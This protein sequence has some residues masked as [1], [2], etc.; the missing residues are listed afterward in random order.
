MI[1]IFS[2]YGD[3]TTTQVCEWLSFYEVDFIRVNGDKEV[4]FDSYDNV[5]NEIVFKINNRKVNLNQAAIVWYRKAGLGL[6]HFKSNYQ[7]KDA[8][9]FLEGGN[10]LKHVVKNENKTLAKYFHWEIEKKQTL[11]KEYNA[12]LNKLKTL[13]IAKECGLNVPKSYVLTSKK[14]LIKLLDCEEA[15]ISK[16]IKDGI[17]EFRENHAYYTYSEK[18]VKEN[19]KDYPDIFSP[20][21][22]QGLIDKKYELRVFFFDNRFYSMAIFSQEYETTSIDYRRSSD[23][24][25]RKIPFELPREQKSKLKDLMNKLDLNTGS[26]DIIVDKENNYVFL[27]VNPVGQFSMVSNPCNYYLEQ[28]V[29]N[30]LWKKSQNNTK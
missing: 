29:A 14:D 18:V 9:F 8:D 24:F 13:S 28:K 1:L 17:Y 2:I 7:V 16:A 25:I 30:Y 26:I 23:Q 21:L 22:F 5:S 6:L 27:E 15:L 12:D 20:T 4:L 3:Y 10:L 19:L 11:G